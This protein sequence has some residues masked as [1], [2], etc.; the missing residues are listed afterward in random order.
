MEKMQKTKYWIKTGIWAGASAGNILAMGSNP[1]LD[2]VLDH[3]L[4]KMDGKKAGFKS[5]M[6]GKGGKGGEEQGGNYGG[7]NEGKRGG[8]GGKGKG[9]KKLMKG[10]GGDDGPDAFGITQRIVG[11]TQGALNEGNAAINGYQCLTGFL[12]DWTY[13][14]TTWEDPYWYQWIQASSLTA[15]WSTEGD[16]FYAIQTGAD[17][18]GLIVSIVGIFLVDQDKQQTRA[19]MHS[20]KELVSTFT[21]A[22]RLTAKLTL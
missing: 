21:S 18:T 14:I 6:G 15:T 13:P 20:V 10:K 8:K 2:M 19:I 11:G 5:L 17:V 1:C 7:N 22:Y 3:E 12:D 16:L 9:G 4:S